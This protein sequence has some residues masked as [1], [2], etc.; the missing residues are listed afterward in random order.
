MPRNFSTIYFKIP[1]TVCMKH[2]QSE[3]SKPLPLINTFILQV[4]RILHDNPTMKTTIMLL[5]HLAWRGISMMLALSVP[6]QMMFSKH[7]YSNTHLTGN[8]WLSI[9]LNNSRSPGVPVMFIY[10][11][12]YTVQGVAH[13]GLLKNNSRKTSFQLVYNGVGSKYCTLTQKLSL[14]WGPNWILVPQEEG[15]FLIFHSWHHLISHR[16]NDKF[17][18]ECVYCT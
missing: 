16:C 2:K 8:E 17:L 14:L 3:T 15:Y 18:C 9:E 10:C 13:C 6:L 1:V 12:Y 4:M 7:N 5:W 11:P